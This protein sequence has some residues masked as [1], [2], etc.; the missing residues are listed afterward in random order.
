[1]Q[2]LGTVLILLVTAFC[3][4][5]TPS[6][7]RPGSDTAPPDV[8]TVPADATKSQSGLATKILKQGT[9]N[10]RPAKDE[11]VVVAY[12]GWTADGKVFDSTVTRGRPSTLNLSRVLPGLSEGV[13]LMVVGETRRLWIPESLAFK[14]QTGKPAGPLVFDITL[15]DMPMRA[16]ADVKGPPDE[17]TRTAS[18][19]YYKVLQPGAGKRHPTKVDEVTVNYTGW[20]TDGKMFDSSYSRGEPMTL[21]L[22]RVIP[23]W[24]EGMA[25]MVEGEKTRFWIPE[26]LAY[27]GR[28]PRGMLVFDVELIRIR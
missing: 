14:G 6:Q 17:A 24:A 16:P 15:L 4:Q 28:A 3:A 19:L 18:G 26:K 8:A 1:M 5:A 20:T 9:G 2:L 7:Q 13:E 22:D 11:L 27:K 21:P 23:G 25:L 12:T 10:D